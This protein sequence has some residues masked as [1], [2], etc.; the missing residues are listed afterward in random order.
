MTPAC[1]P[2]PSSVR[3]RTLLPPERAI[4]YCRRRRGRSNPRRRSLRIRRLLQRFRET[5]TFTVT[6]RERSVGGAYEIQKLLQRFR[7][8]STFTVTHREQKCWR[9]TIRDSEIASEIQRTLDI[10]GDAPRASVGE[11]EAQSEAV[12]SKCWREG[13]AK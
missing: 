1:W 9:R 6:H 4:R 7:E 13:G 2:K 5:S 11:K 12:F 8:T 3:Y 10:Y